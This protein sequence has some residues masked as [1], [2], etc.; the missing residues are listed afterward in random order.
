[1]SIDL[2]AFLYAILAMYGLV[3]ICAVSIATLGV[4]GI[5][6]YMKRA[7]SESH[8]EL[9]SAHSVPRTQ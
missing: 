8:E 2:G 6:K 9:L 5:A 7:A 3:G 4:W 1:M